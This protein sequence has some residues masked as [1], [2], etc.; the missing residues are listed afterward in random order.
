MIYT[1]PQNTA[2]DSSKRLTGPSDL[3]RERFH[4]GRFTDTPTRKYTVTTVTTGGHESLIKTGTDHEISKKI[5]NYL[6]SKLLYTASTS[7]SLSESLEKILPQLKDKFPEST[8]FADYESDHDNPNIIRLV[9]RL[10][11]HFES[12]DEWKKTKS[13]FREI[14][15]SN[16]P[17][18]RIFYPIL[19]TT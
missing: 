16:T 3:N 17:D 10:K 5:V 9:I 2:S 13:K 4:H 11:K 6:G 19:E 12:V 18:N 14:V 15:N 8:I 7:K 1:N